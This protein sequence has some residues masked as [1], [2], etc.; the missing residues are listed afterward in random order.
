MS[1]DEEE[2]EVLSGG[3]EDGGGLPPWVTR[4]L[5]AVLVVPL[6]VAVGRGLFLK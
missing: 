2:R 4:G 1:G 6:L 3:P 5:V